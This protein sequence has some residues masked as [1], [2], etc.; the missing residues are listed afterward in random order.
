MSDYTAAPKLF[1][2]AVAVYNLMA[3]RADSKNGDLIFEGRTTE[4][5]KDL[6]LGTNQYTPIFRYL[7][8][9]GCVLQLRRGGG[10]NTSAFQLNHPPEIETFDA[11]IEHSNAKESGTDRAIASIVAMTNKLN[12]MQQTIDAHSRAIMTLQNLVLKDKKVDDGNI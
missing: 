3:E 9:S 1:K 11:D 10:G 6:E 4:I 2:H 5:L 12:A 7:K 8:G